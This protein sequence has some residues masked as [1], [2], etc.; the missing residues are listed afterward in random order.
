MQDIAER[1]ALCTQC[2]L[3]KTRTNVVTGEGSTHPDIAFI[4]EGPGAQ[5]DKKGRAF[6]GP[7]GDILTRLIEKMRYTRED[8]WIGNIVKCRASVNFEM[9]RDRPPTLD[10]MHTCLP[11]L[12]E[13]LAII[14]PK[15]IVTLGNVAL[16]GLLG[17]RGITRLHGQWRTYDGINLMPTYHP[18]YL[19]RNRGNNQLYWDV[20]HD[21]EKVLARLRGESDPG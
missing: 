13:Q 17:V 7:A 15:V 19:L 21:M 20:W 5:E 14:R 2:P 9:N 3:H 10:E 11:F 18:S 12:R 1:I 6:I 8:V 4:G 16:E